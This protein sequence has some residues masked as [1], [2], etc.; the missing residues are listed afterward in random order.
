MLVIG[1]SMSVLIGM[2]K[3]MVQG[4]TIFAVHLVQLVLKMV[5]R[6]EPALLDTLF[7]TLGMV[8]DLLPLVIAVMPMDGCGVLS[9]ETQML[10]LATAL[11]NTLQRILVLLFDILP[12]VLGVIC[13][14][15]TVLWKTTKCLLSG[16]PK[17][18]EARQQEAVDAKSLKSIETP[19][20]LAGLD[21]E[22]TFVASEQQE[23]APPPPPPASS[24]PVLPPP[25]PPLPA[26]P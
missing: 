19:V 5:I 11:I 9:L 4:E 2:P 25:P 12:Q 13:L 15:A 10:M 7:N 23:E 26:P 24:R 21:V 1:W 22:L 8:C 6:P 18:E 20:P 3:A 16:Y 14:V 17:R